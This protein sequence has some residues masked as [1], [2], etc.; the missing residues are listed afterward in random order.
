MGRRN[1]MKFMKMTNDK[2]RVSFFAWSHTFG[3][4]LA[5]IQTI[6]IIWEIRR[7]IKILNKKIK[8]H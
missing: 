3:W 2:D 5:N 6:W 4:I 8:P 1:A 7:G